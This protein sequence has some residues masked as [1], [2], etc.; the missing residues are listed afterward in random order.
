MLQLCRSCWLSSLKYASLRHVPFTPSPCISQCQCS[1]L[2]GLMGK[3]SL[4]HNGH[5]FSQEI[6]IRIVTLAMA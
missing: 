6:T 5:H 2:R 3:L 1:G 4:C